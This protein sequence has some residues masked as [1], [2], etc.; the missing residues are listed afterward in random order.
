MKAKR[1]L[2]FEAAEAGVFFPVRQEGKG[3]LI[4]LMLSEQLQSQQPHSPLWME[5]N[6]SSPTIKH[7]LNC[8]GLNFQRVEG[9]MEGKAQVIFQPIEVLCSPDT[10]FH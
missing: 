6:T 2:H 7:K 10:Y 4:S 3:S 9:V 8:L 5:S 1:F